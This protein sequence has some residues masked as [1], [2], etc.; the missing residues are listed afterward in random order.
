MTPNPDPTMPASPRVLIL[1]HL[2]GDGPAYLGRWLSEQGVPFE[3]RN[4]QAGDAF[5]ASLAGF[6]ALAIL[7]GE[8]S[9]NDDLP[10]LR[11]AEALFREALARGTP[12]LGHCLGGQ[13]MARALGARV[14]ASPK[15]EIGWQPIRWLPDPAV[16]AWFGAAEPLPVVFHWHSESFELPADAVPLASSPACPRQAFALGPHLAMQFHIEV[17]EEKLRRWSL[18]ADGAGRAT[19][20]EGVATHLAAHQRVAAHIYRHWLS[21]CKMSIP[22]RESTG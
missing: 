15:P 13:L 6:D 19:M 2:S 17:D 20:L 4:T 18:D 16:A 10:A 22:Y 11:Q 9:A 12:T 5:P 7:G 1:Q 3:V 14:V 8:M 21:Q